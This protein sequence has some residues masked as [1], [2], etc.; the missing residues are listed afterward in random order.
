MH[1]LIKYLSF[2][3]DFANLDLGKW[4]DILC[5]KQVGSP[6]RLFAFMNMPKKT[7]LKWC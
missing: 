6:I 1:D 5:M 3:L 7:L 4:E 2:A